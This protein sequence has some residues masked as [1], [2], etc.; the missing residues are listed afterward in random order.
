MATK[1]V[2][3]L[4]PGSIE[5]LDDD[6]MVITL[7]KMSDDGIMD[8]DPNEWLTHDDSLITDTV[9]IQ[10]GDKTVRLKIAALT[11]KEDNQLLKLAR[12]L[13]PKNPRGSGKIDFS[14]YRRLQIALSLS[15]AS[16]LVDTPQ[17]ITEAA[18]GGKLTGHLT[19]IQKAIMKLSGMDMDDN[20]STPDLSE[21]FG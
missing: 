16:G 12:K 19:T 9:T 17:Q 4:A 1:E 15:K 14:R 13:D 8:I 5:E 18:L 21:F 20:S 3:I 2:D 6:P 10:Q 7:D 11:E